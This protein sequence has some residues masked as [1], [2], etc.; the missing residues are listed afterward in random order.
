M[1][2]E[3]DPGQGSSQAIVAGAWEWMDEKDSFD[4]V[5]AISSLSINSA[6]SPSPSPMLQCFSSECGSKAPGD[7]SESDNDNYHDSSAARPGG[8]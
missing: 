7:N 1:I 4:I 5:K 6:C 3:T 2:R 8:F